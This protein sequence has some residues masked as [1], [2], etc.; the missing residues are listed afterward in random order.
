MHYKEYI[1]FTE[2]QDVSIVT[3]SHE[4]SQF[5]CQI[6]INNIRSRIQLTKNIRSTISFVSENTITFSNL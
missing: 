2:T 4:L 6:M 1:T 5:I 3:R